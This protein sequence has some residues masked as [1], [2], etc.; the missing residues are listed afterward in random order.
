MMLSVNTPHITAEANC[1]RH[2]ALKDRIGTQGFALRK[3]RRVND[4]LDSFRQF[5]LVHEAFTSHGPLSMDQPHRTASLA[6][7]LCQLSFF[8]TTPM[9]SAGSFCFPDATTVDAFCNRFGG[10]RVS[11]RIRR[12]RVG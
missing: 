9:G 11:G 2:H 1:R 12:L 10:L 3:G 4:G 6:K 8:W 5:P 7:Y